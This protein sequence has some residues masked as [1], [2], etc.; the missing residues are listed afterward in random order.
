MI[1]RKLRQANVEPISAH[2]LRYGSMYS[3]E[4]IES[5]LK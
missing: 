2:D 5:A 3:R 4:E 1:I